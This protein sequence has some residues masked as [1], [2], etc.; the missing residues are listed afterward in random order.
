[1]P[2]HEPWGLRH[3]GHHLLAQ[4]AF[5]DI[6]IAD[7]DRNDD[8]VHRASFVAEDNRVPVGANRGK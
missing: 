5:G 7:R 4:M 8:C 6:L 1:V 3:R 2:S